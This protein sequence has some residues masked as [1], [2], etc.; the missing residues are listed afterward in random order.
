VPLQPEVLLE[1]LAVS[2]PSLQ[3]LCALAATPDKAV[4]LLRAGLRP[5]PAVSG[6][7]IAP[8]IAAL[9]ADTFVDRVRAEAELEKLGEAAEPALRQYLGKNI[10]LEPRR[11]VE[12]LLYRLADC[13]RRAAALPRLEAL[14]RSTRRGLAVLRTLVDARR[15]HHRGGGALRRLGR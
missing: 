13:G 4:V 10:P 9:D 12:R 14:Q 7:R 5:V 6:Q 2:T 8:L 11:R 3:A 15:P 1:R